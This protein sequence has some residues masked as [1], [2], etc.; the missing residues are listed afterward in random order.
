ML[1][2]EKQLLLYDNNITGF[3]N[4]LQNSNN[5]YGDKFHPHHVYNAYISNI[6]EQ[7]K[8]YTDNWFKAYVEI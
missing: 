5:W 2:L 7:A 3:M 4:I 8:E 1:E 6:H